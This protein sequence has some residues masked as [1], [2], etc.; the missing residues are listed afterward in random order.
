NNNWAWHDD[1]IPDTKIIYDEETIVT[2]SMGNVFVS[3]KIRKIVNITKIENVS[4]DGGEYPPYGN[5][6]VVFGTECYY[7]C[8]SSQLIAYNMTDIYGD[9]TNETIPL[10]MFGYNASV[11]KAHCLGYYRSPA[12]LIIPLNNSALNLDAIAQIINATYYWP[13]AEFGYINKFDSIS[14]N[15]GKKQV[16]FQNT[17]EGYFLNATFFNNGTVNEIDAEFLM[18]IGGENGT[19]E[20]ATI[21][22]KIR[23]AF[24]YDLVDEVSWD[25]SVGDELYYGDNARWSYWNGSYEVIDGRYN[26]VKITIDEIDVGLFPV[27]ASW[28]FEYMQCFSYVFANIS[29]WNPVTQQYEPKGEPV[30]MGLANELVPANM[31]ILMGGMEDQFPLGRNIL[32]DEPILFVND[33]WSLTVAYNSSYMDWDNKILEV[34]YGGIPT[35]DYYRIYDVQNNDY[36]NI[37]IYVEDWGDNPDFY[38]INLTTS[39]TISIFDWGEQNDGPRFFFY[40]QNIDPEDAKFVLEG[41]MRANMGHEFDTFN[42][43]SDGSYVFNNTWDLR[44]ME[45]KF[46]LATGIL[47][48]YYFTDNNTGEINSITFR[49]NCTNIPIGTEQLV[50]YPSNMMFDEL[51]SAQ[52]I[53]DMTANANVDIYSAVLPYN[54]VISP[55]HAEIETMPFYIDLYAS[56]N[57]NIEANSN[58]TFIYD[59]SLLG[60]V[61]EGNLAPYAYDMKEDRW[62]IA[63]EDIYTIDTSTNTIFIQM[64]PFN[65]NITYFSVGVGEEWR[66]GVN[67][68]DLI[69]S[70]TQGV[71]RNGSEIMPYNDFTTFNITSIEGAYH[72]SLEWVQVNAS[73]MYHDGINSL[74]PNG[75]SL[76]AGEM[77]VDMD[78]NLVMILSPNS[79]GIP[80]IVPLQYG[81]LNLSAV[82]S[83]LRDFFVSPEAAAMGYPAFDGWIANGNNLV[84]TQAASPYYMDLTYYD[85]GTIEECDVY[86]TVMSGWEIQ[87]VSRREFDPNP[88]NDVSW[89]VSNGDT[90]YY[91]NPDERLR[92][93]IT[94]A[95]DNS[96]ER[97]SDL[98]LSMNDGSR[99]A[100]LNLWAEVY[101]WNRSTLSWQYFGEQ[102]VA[103]ANEYFLFSFNNSI[104]SSENPEFLF[105]PAGTTGSMIYE[106]FE[107]LTDLT[108]MDTPTTI[109]IDYIRLDSSTSEAF[110]D[111]KFNSTSGV[112]ELAVGNVRS[113]E[114]PGEYHMFGRYL[115]EYQTSIGTATFSFENPLIE[116]YT[117]TVN[118]T[119]ANPVDIYYAMI[120][121]VPGGITLGNGTMIFYCD[122]LVRNLSSSDNL[123][124][125][126]VLPL[127]INITEDFTKFRFWY[128]DPESQD[129]QDITGQF[130][131]DLLLGT[132]E[133]AI[134]VDFMENYESGVIDLVFAISYEGDLS[135]PPLVS[136]F[137][138]ITILSAI[139]LGAIAIYIRK[140][141]T[142]SLT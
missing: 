48:W 33:E 14:V 76:M 86:S 5:T 113:H 40:P 13:F 120:S 110:F 61:D 46:D 84:I 130:I 38:D 108:E 22:T 54:P 36:N 75:W 39:N 131:A 109:E 44:K 105:L 128:W 70:L 81:S 104:G 115:M 99:C 57:L 32:D 129:W 65:P 72:D 125:M 138:I 141:K 62:M 142:I 134:I 122:L 28:G 92:L 116:G 47:D 78:G 64:G 135:E 11:D 26:E 114:Y 91:G 52:L 89:G 25:F 20:M 100:F 21:K 66:W 107:P 103:R 68:G 63:P 34:L 111:W 121:D 94:D 42:V 119:T 117:T 55:F 82:G 53:L 98:M 45:G 80:L 19:M 79:W 112:S 127:T 90:F 51:G 60:G 102:I 95:M 136:G 10:A 8:T 15:A 16:S 56:N 71:V 30:M 9:E 132:T 49:K 87:L 31:M 73:G 35:G 126:F 140:R 106:F 1:I 133:S 17:T 43:F 12:I 137:T 6:S 67:E 37:T 118:L 96:T 74:L 4:L 41:F 7:N 3:Y 58:L 27:Y 97:L 29:F 83:A 69:T 124:F 88:I 18:S 59:E 24:D 2:D 77:S 85:N 93:T 139:S 23:R 50:L 101:I 123:T